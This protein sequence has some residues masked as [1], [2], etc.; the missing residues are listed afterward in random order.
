M[1]S[2]LI[3]FQ[4]T[5]PVCSGII[6]YPVDMVCTVCG[7]QVLFFTRKPEQDIIDSLEKSSKARLTDFM[8]SKTADKGKTE[9]EIRVSELAVRRKTLE[10]EY[11]SLKT[12]VL[13]F[14]SQ[15]AALKED[16]LLHFNSEGLCEAI[17]LLTKKK[18]EL[19]GYA[20]DAE[21]SQQPLVSVKC[22]YNSETNTVNVETTH[23]EDAAPAELELHIG[24]AVANKRFT[25]FTDTDIIFPLKESCRKLRVYEKGQ[26]FQLE[27]TA[28]P[29]GGVVDYEVVHL[30]A[31]NLNKF[32]IE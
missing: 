12:Q 4:T 15:K 11:E 30:Y 26:F 29:V 9:M 22:S 14:E 17:E 1:N 16:P 2:K 23:V 7:W 19:E 28:K 24:V 21:I 8:Q 10:L 6:K 27:L 5:C 32:T 18:A 13:L 20:V 25:H 31:N 3:S